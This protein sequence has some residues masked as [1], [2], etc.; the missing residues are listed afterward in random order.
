MAVVQFDY[1]SEILSRSIEMNIRQRV[2]ATLA[3]G[4][5][6]GAAIFTRAGSL[7]AY[8]RDNSRAAVATLTGKFVS[9]VPG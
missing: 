4:S 1:R 7:K 8:A 3:M 2:D 6:E 9:V 5:A